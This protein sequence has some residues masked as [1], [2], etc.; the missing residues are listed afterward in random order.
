MGVRRGSYAMYLNINHPD[1]LQFIDMRKPTG[2]HNIRCLN[3]HHGL[4]IS[5]EFMELI[6]K[7][8]GGGNIDDTW[9]LIDPH[10]KK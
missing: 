6:E 10:T 1:V 4:N 2:D 3:L 8:D 7:C 9:N 5:D